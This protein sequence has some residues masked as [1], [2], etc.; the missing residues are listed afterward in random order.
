MFVE[1]CGELWDRRWLLL[2]VQY[3]LIYAVFSGNLVISRIQKFDAGTYLC[4]VN[5]SSGGALEKVINVDVFG[6]QSS[7]A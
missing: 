7:Y 6:E 1:L 4:R 3:I 2:R 5:K